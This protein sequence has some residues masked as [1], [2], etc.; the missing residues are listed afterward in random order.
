M[1][2]IHTSDVHLARD[3]PE[4]L[5]AL[6]AVLALAAQREADLLVVAGDL[7]DSDAEAR[8]LRP[9]LR[10]RFTGTG[11]TTIIAAGNHDRRSYAAGLD[12]GDAVVACGGDSPI[13]LNHG[14]V[15][16][17]V[18]PYTDLPFDRLA[19]EL[20]A[21]AEDCVNALLVI[22]CTLDFPD[23]DAGQFGDEGSARY[24]PVT[25][26]ALGQ[27]GYSRI[28]GGHFHNHRLQQL[29]DACT[30][31]YSGSPVSVTARELGRR[32]VYLLD[33]ETGSI[34]R[35]QLDSFH[36]VRERVVLVPGQVAAGLERLESRLAELAHHEAAM[37]VEVTGFVDVPEVE[38]G[39]RLQLLR[40]KHP[41]LELETSYRDAKAALEHPLYG[42]F[43]KLLEHGDHAPEDA[44]RMQATLLAALADQLVGGR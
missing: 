40:S 35:L 4:R 7:F 26:R 41:S 5:R 6:D 1:K 31:L 11:F 3:R 44:G 37:E 15:L 23:L 39:R 33:T 42:R 43:L 22:H 16:V 38:V 36:R 13:A 28:L 34:E 30:F 2:V 14:G 24:L 19:P 9:E 25:S 27:L 29:G 21:L 17:V 18:Q 20:E 8:A 10:S 12:Y 32:G